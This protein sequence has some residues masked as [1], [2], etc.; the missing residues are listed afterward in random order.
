MLLVSL[1]A[2]DVPTYTI[3]RIDNWEEKEYK[4][5]VPQIFKVLKSPKSKRTLL[6]ILIVEKNGQIK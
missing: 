4:E 3:L 5:S 2:A 6:N 1:E